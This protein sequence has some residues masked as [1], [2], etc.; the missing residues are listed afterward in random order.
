MT[1][2]TCI[3]EKWLE[4][5]LGLVAHEE[6]RR[7]LLWL[8]AMETGEDART[9]ERVD[10]SLRARL[11]FFLGFSFDALGALSERER[12]REFGRLYDEHLEWLCGIRASA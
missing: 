6:S 9:L 11:A 8:R 12:A 10:P 7:E 5:Y 2:T 3:D 4:A 1:T